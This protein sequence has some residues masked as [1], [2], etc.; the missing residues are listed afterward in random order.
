MPVLL[1]TAC[2]EMPGTSRRHHDRT[3]GRAHEH[4]AWIWAVAL[5]A[6]LV[7]GALMVTAFVLRTRG[8][9]RRDGATGPG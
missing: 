9:A 5:L 4:D 2:D 3:G 8:R 7:T 6:A 1:G